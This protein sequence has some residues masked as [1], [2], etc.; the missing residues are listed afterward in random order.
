VAPLVASSTAP[1][2]LSSSTSPPLLSSSTLSPTPA[3]PR[4]GGGEG[5]GCGDVA[6]G[7]V[8]SVSSPVPWCGLAWSWLV[9]SPSFVAHPPCSCSQRNMTCSDSTALDTLPSSSMPRERYLATILSLSAHPSRHTGACIRVEMQHEM[10]HAHASYPTTL[11]M[12][13]TLNR[14]MQHTLNHLTP[15]PHS[16]HMDTRSRRRV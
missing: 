9:A 3:A 1:P 11:Q 10:Q 13:H 6:C 5:G 14:E 15:R 12:Q 7:D 4:S 8:A 2:L 16:K